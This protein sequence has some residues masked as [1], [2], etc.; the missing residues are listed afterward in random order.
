MSGAGRGSGTGDA[1][2]L[3]INSGSSSLKLAA[4]RIGPSREERVASGVVSGIGSGHGAI[5]ARVAGGGEM[6]RGVT[7]AGM[8]DAVR[9][10]FE[11]LGALAIRPDAVGHR[12]VHGGGAHVRPERI[13]PALVAS[14]RRLVPFA[15]IHLP[16]QIDAID[17]VAELAPGLMQAAC[18]DTAFHARMPE[19]A[20]RFALPRA[21]FDEGVRRYG[22]HGLSYEYVVDHV[23]A[24]ALGRAVIAH[25]GNGAS[26]AAVDR[27]API[28]TTMG[29]TPAGGIMMGTRSGD[30]DPG[31]LCYLAAT[32]GYSADDLERLVDREAGLLGVSGSTH[33]M[34]VLLRRR[35]IDDAA[36]LAVAMFVYQARKAIGALAAALGGIDT[37][38]F[39]GGIGEHAAE[40][41]A[42]IAEGL[43]HLG[44]IVDPRRNAA[45]SGV[46]SA[47]GAACVVRVVATD[48]ERM[49]A[50]HT[51]ALLTGP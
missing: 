43:A 8:A 1:L 11:A 2:V 17:A 49:I 31:V 3:A 27:G 16:P 20:A 44:V 13:G 9:A 50:R 35:V 6:E 18:F 12:I 15:P 22:F 19:V 24:E 28:D 7:L 14:L 10:I 45:P 26:L 37:L 32:K 36:R 47:D 29:L 4:F 5:R 42:E 46:I 39:T 34:E 51:R 25:L 33:D 30:I 40:I 38:V 23:G 21:L 41:R 48:E